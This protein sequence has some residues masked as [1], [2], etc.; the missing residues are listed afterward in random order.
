M[1]NE[2]K[3]ISRAIKRMF[4]DMFQG[5]L[6]GCC[7]VLRPITIG[8]VGKWMVRIPCIMLV[9]AVAMAPITLLILGVHYGYIKEEPDSFANFIGTFAMVLGSLLWLGLTVVCSA[10]SIV[11]NYEIEK[12]KEQK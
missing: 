1:F 12:K 2:F 8:N 5:I 3:L 6:K 11:K 10:T 7:N 9:I 4:S